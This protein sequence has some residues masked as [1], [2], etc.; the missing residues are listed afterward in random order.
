[1]KKN[2]IK[3]IWQE[4]GVAINGWLSIPSSVSAEFMTHEGWDSLT[5]DMQ[6]GLNDYSSTVSMLQVISSTETIPFVRIPWND[7]EIIMKMLNVNTYG[8][9]CPMINSQQECENFVNAC[10][11]PYLGHRNVSSNNE[12]ITMAM[13]ETKKGVENLDS[14]LSV[15]GL[16]SIY[17]GPADLSFSYIQKPDFDILDPP[18]FQVI[19]SIVKKAKDKNIYAGIHVGSTDYAH[20]MIELGFQF[21]SILSEIKIMSN[22]TQEILREMKKNKFKKNFS[23]Y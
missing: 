23:T 15:N 12:V 16:D 4:G 13:I 9:I 3:K 20:K 7:P 10:R 2:K 22:A 21:I 18:V 1:M 6:H 19:E 5:I 14:I 17:I 8:I 11:Y